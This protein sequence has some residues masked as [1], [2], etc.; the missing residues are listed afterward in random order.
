MFSVE[1]DLSQV[2]INVLFEYCLQEMLTRT[3]KVNK[4]T[5]VNLKHQFSIQANQFSQ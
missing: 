5:I 1:Q 3:V 4:D 2:Y